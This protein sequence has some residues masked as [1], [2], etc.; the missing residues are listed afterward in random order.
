M[1]M[2]SKWIMTQY[3]VPRHR[4]HGGATPQDLVRVISTTLPRRS[5][6]RAVVPL[7]LGLGGG[8]VLDDR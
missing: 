2:G 4:L 6:A 7:A 8:K 5:A 3:S 1:G